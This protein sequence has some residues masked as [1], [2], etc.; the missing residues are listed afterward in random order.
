M[1]RFLFRQYT[2]PGA[3]VS[4]EPESDLCK[5]ILTQGV[6]ETSDGVCV[7]RQRTT[8]QW[9]LLIENVVHT[10]QDLGITQEAKR[11]ID[12]KIAL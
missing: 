2:L 5:Q 10:N 11:R 9:W 3:T 8:H 12:I 7:G 4:L 6:V 1:T